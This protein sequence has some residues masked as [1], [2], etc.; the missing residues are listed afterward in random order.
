M[1]TDLNFDPLIPLAIWASL[2]V[3]A[4]AVILLSIVKDLKGWVWRLLAFAVVFL[5]LLQPSVVRE[6]RKDRED[7]VLVLTDDT[8]SQSLG[9]RPSQTKAAEQH[10]MALLGAE[11]NLRVRQARIQDAENNR[12]TQLVSKLEE[13]L[14]EERADQIAGVIVITDGVVHDIAPLPNLTAPMHVFLSGEKYGFDRRLIVKN[15]PAYAIV[16][17]TI[18]VTLRVDDLG[19]MPQSSNLVGL[20][21]S[22][23]G[24][25]EQRLQ[26]PSNKDVDVVIRL[27]HGGINIFE[28]RLDPLE[29]ELTEQNNNVLLQ[30]NAIRDRLR[31]LLVSG[32]PHPGTRTWRNLLK[33]DSSVDLVH[34]TILRPP[35]KQDGVPVD[36]LSLIAF[37]TRELFLEKIDDFDLIIFDRYK[38]RG[39]LPA[40]YLDNI[41]RYVEDGGAV[42]VSAG[43]DFATVNSLY[44][45]PLARVL[46]VEPTSRIISKPFVPRLSEDGKR[47][48]VSAELPAPDTWGRWFQQVQVVPK[49]GSVLMT[50]AEEQPLLIL[51]RVEQGR[52]SLIASDHTWLWDRKFE[53]GGPQLEL[54]RRLAHWMMGEAELEEEALI[55]EQL[56][57]IVRILRRTMGEAP[58]EVLITSPSG[59]ISKHSFAPLS[60]YGSYQAIFESEEQGL[61]QMETPGLKG[62]FAMG[63]ASPKEFENPLST[64][65]ILKPLAA[66]AG[67]GMFWITDGLPRLRRVEPLRP[68]AGRNWFA[69]TPRRAFDT[70]DVRK[71]PLAPAW[72]ITLLAGGLLLVGWLFEGRRSNAARIDKDET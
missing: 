51:D 36:E 26:L 46:P 70:L 68:A 24:E 43:P 50:G 38:R 40:S 39:I 19:P 54:L 13:L 55:A 44:R 63:P 41:A 25:R 6:E 34:F 30:I 65:E 60:K 15:A 69:I 2:A 11:A 22:V 10:V 72:L 57:G 20:T 42:L 8:K 3:F 71:I 32:E 4:C 53:G 61:F 66:S 17:E 64:P 48:P 59:A 29:G 56:E 31:V 9:D 21:V 7:I 47:H 23:D 37:P 14:A 33:S 18:S 52:I 58:R 27:P 1:I 62:V 16:G 49:S 12:G 35:G 28:L 5:A 67:G 45:S